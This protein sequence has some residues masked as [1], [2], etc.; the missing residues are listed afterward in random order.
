VKKI[1]TLLLVAIIGV[2]VFLY[3][4]RQSAPISGEVKNAQEEEKLVTTSGTDVPESTDFSQLRIPKLGVKAHIEYVGLDS[5]SR[6]DVPKNDMNVAWYKHGPKPGEIGS[7]VIAGHFDTKTGAPAVFN[8]ISKLVPGDTVIVE[9][10]DNKQKVFSV[11]E[12]KI[13]KD[14]EFPI[15]EVFYQKDIERLNLITCDGVY[16]EN[17][18]TYSDRLVVFTKLNAN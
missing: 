7:A 13:F 8:Q 15:S 17:K 4:S 11:I 16:D 5:T 6:M 12:T 9:G 2:G 14:E 3:F 1:I 10:M 18:K